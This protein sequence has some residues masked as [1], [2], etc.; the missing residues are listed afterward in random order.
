M[1]ETRGAKLVI[2]GGAQT[3]KRRGRPKGRW[4]DSVKRDLKAIGVSDWENQ[5]QNR[6]VWR[7]LINK[8]MGLLGLQS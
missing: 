5:A 4:I 1:R 3:K 2:R 6:V 7:T 8:A